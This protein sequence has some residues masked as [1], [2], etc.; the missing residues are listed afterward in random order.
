[1]PSPSIRRRSKRQNDLI[2]E[3]REKERLLAERLRQQ[4]EDANRA[5]I[6][7]W[8]IWPQGP[9]YD[10]LYIVQPRRQPP[11]EEPQ[12]EEPPPQQPAKPP[13]G[14]PIPIRPPL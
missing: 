6:P 12:P 5:R 2:L 13:P 11:P 10:D 9:D 14:Q 7:D 3:Q 4:Q 8:H 1:M